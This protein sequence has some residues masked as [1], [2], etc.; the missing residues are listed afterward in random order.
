[1]T[2]KEIEK[3]IALIK[4]LLELRGK[5]VSKGDVVTAVN[6]GG[7]PGAKKVTATGGPVIDTYNFEATKIEVGWS[8][9]YLATLAEENKGWPSSEEAWTNIEKPF[10]NESTKC[11]CK[12]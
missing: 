11:S 5:L 3:E 6:F 8:K 1:M 10:Y 4:E 2:I 12:F 7:Y 9:D